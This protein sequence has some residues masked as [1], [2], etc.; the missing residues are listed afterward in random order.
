MNEIFASQSRLSSL[1]ET[2]VN[3]LIGLVVAITTQ[4][5]I[6]PFY[7]IFIPFSTNITMSLCF[8]VVSIIRTYAVR[9]WFN[10]ILGGKSQS[11]RGSLHETSVNFL[12]GYCTAIF[13]QAVIFPLFGIDAT[14]HENLSIALWFSVISLIRSYVIRRWFNARLHNASIRISNVKSIHDLYEKMSIGFSLLKSK[15]WA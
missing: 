8:T 13:S 7:G 1:L 12:L 3:I 14:I 6:F 4:V 5:L 9:R 2:W 15:I 11:R 10:H